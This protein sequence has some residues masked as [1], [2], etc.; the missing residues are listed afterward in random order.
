MNDDLER[1]LREALRSAP[2]PDA[3]TTLRQGLANLAVRDQGRARA[4]QPSVAWLVPAVAAGL[5]AVAVLGVLGPSRTLPVPSGSAQPTR[6]Q[7]ASPTLG[8]ASPVDDAGMFGSGGLWAARGTSLY[9]SKDRGASWMQRTLVAS[10]ALDIDDGNVLSDLFVLDADHAWTASPGPGST[11]WTGQGPPTDSLHLVISRTSD[12]GQTWQST[13]LLGDFA[14]TQPVLA[15]T[16]PTHGFLLLSPLRFGLVESTLL[17]TRDGGATWQ[18]DSHDGMLG[19]IFLATQALPA[20]DATTLWAGNQGDAGPV[21][22][23]ILQ[24]S[25]IDARGGPIQ[26][27]VRLWTDAGLPGLI[28]DTF[29]TDVVA[30]GPLVWGS[31][32][33]VAINVGASADPPETRFYSSRD[34]GHSWKLAAKAPMSNAVAIIDPSHFVTSGPIPGSFSA[35]TDAGATW[36][37]YPA[38]A[39]PGDPFGHGSIRFWDSESGMAIVRLGDTPAPNGL[40]LTEDGGRTW[41]PVSFPSATAS[42]TPI[43]SPGPTDSPVPTSANAIAYFDADRGLLAGS[44]G[45]DGGPTSGVIW[46]TADGGK[47][48]TVAARMAAAFSSL[49]TVGGEAWAGA[50]CPGASGPCDPGVWSSGDGGATWEQMSTT[51][52]TSLVFADATHGWATQLG[53]APGPVIGP[54][55]ASLLSTAD[56]GRTWTTHLDP[57]GAGIGLAVAV[58]FPD[59]SHGWV[60]CTSNG[61]STNAKGVVATQDGGKT[62]VLRSAVRVPGEG[63]SVGTIEGGDYMIGLAMRPDGT[64]IW[65]GG[66]GVTE[67]TDDGGAT[68]SSTPPGDFDVKIPS[69]AWLVDDQH[70]VIV[71]WDGDLG[72]QVLVETLDG[73]QTWNRISLLPPK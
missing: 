69:A 28:G 71:L 54:L 68:W 46:R 36:E 20:T 45:P 29:V 8:A 53:P 55:I 66:R 57:C 38:S 62:W 32:G 49:A 17:A 3:P 19:S 61:A 39:L 25:R 47:T 9:L 7:V 50:S 72:S 27:R 30:A 11:P 5:L 48:W 41:S 37:T 21:A 35:T 12:G 6:T 2:L 73:G 63:P 26:G 13:P 56:G 58:A 67:R 10:V 64:G 70:W 43:P 24:A 52:V 22:R 31:D 65:W 23:P 40:F 51:P 60:G 4:T 59:A 33:V 1:H 15:F 14:G 16:D 18:V 34:A 42:P 44:T